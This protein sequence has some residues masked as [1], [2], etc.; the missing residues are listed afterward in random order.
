M[1]ALFG[2]GHQQPKPGAEAAAG[3]EKD[4]PASEYARL[5][6]FVV[7]FLVC[8]NAVLSYA[9]LGSKKKGD[10]KESRGRTHAG[11]LEALTWSLCMSLMLLYFFGTLDSSAVGT[12]AVM[13]WVSFWLY[14]AIC[15][16]ILVGSEVSV[17][18][19]FGYFAFN[20]FI[21]AAFAWL[22]AVLRS[23]M[24]ARGSLE[25]V[26]TR[27]TTKLSEIMG[28]QAALA[29]IAVSQGIGPKAS[30]RITATGLFQLS[31]IMAW[32][33]STAIFDVSGVDPR[34]AVTKMRLSLVEGAALFSTGILVLSGFNLYFLS[35]QS[36]IKRRTLNIV[37]NIFIFSIIGGFFCTA[38]VV[39]VA[40]RRRRSKVRDSD[41]E[42]PEPPA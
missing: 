2:S 37:S 26:T 41:C 30:K 39:W 28:L 29:A 18:G 38:R 12:R 19:A 32:L 13:I 24:R 11:H 35:E 5:Q 42:D 10:L 21:A 7:A 23:E 27:I 9:T 15:M 31:L 16:A 36:R 8:D 22:I 6:W 40:R 3:D 33:F 14:Q 25:T 4:E 1:D 34:L 20:A 17:I